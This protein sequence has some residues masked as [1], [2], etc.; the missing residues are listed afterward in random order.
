MKSRVLPHICTHP[1]SA[2]LGDRQSSLLPG[3]VRTPQFPLHSPLTD[4]AATSSLWEEDN[5]RNNNRNNNNDIGE[6]E[7][8]Q[9]PPSVT[10]PLGVYAKSE[11]WCTGGSAAAPLAV[12]SFTDAH[13][14]PRTTIIV[15]EAKSPLPQQLQQHQQLEAAAVAATTTLATSMMVGDVG[16]DVSSATRGGPP[17]SAEPHVEATEDE[18]VVPVAGE[19]PVPT[20]TN[21]STPS[22][23]PSGTY[24]AS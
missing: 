3:Q 10:T 12:P 1:L 11:V 18:A 19:L 6:R 24:T 2:D 22:P 20:P 9:Y 15:T 17:V 8:S 21:V 14:K 5:G 23:T 7:D 16:T 4:W 13:A